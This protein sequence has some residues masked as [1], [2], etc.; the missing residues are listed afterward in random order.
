[1]TV[2]KVRKV[3]VG[4][5]LVVEGVLSEEQLAEALALQKTEGI[6]LGEL[7][8]SKG[9]ISHTVLVRTLSRCLGVP[10]CVLRHGLMD[11]ALMEIIGEEE[12]RRLKVI[13]MFKVHDTLTVAMA[14]PQALPALD[15]LRRLTGCKIRAVLALEPNIAEFA[16]KYAGGHADIDGFLATLT[17]SEVEVVERETVDEGPATDLDQMVAG[18]PIINLVNMALLRAIKDGASDIHIEPDRKGTRVRHRVDGHL[19]EL[20]N[21][22]PGMHAAIVSRVKVMSKMDVAEKR[23]PQEGRIRIVAEKRDID[24]RVSSMPTLLADAPSVQ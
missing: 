22:P 5:A 21:P 19:R 18:S 1:M 3:R 9:M 6:R 15:T 11:P 10:G 20:M 14:E 13:P 8:V 4:E 23:L 16:G 24:L 7:L 17:D 2:E 12:A